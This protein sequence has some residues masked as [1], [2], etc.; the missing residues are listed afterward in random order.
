MW[1]K[2]RKTCNFRH[3]NLEW[4]NDYENWY[5][6]HL[7]VTM[8]YFFA[9]IFCI[10]FKGRGDICSIF[11]SFLSNQFIWFSTTVNRN[12]KKTKNEK[13]NWFSPSASLC[14]K[15]FGNAKWSYL[16]YSCKCFRNLCFIN[17]VAVRAGF[18]V[19]W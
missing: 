13:I 3:A 6:K 9:F 5:Q 12:K 4:Q 8:N 18:W 10:Y 11:I 16:S 1:K 2:F 14:A 15:L 7:L 19:Y 17:L